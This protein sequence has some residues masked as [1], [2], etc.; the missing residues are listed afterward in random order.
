[1]NQ[2]YI[3]ILFLVSISFL[4]S[5]QEVFAANVLVVDDDTGDSVN[6]DGALQA[7]GHTVTTVTN[8][9]VGGSNPTLQGTLSQYDAVYWTASGGIGFGEVHSDPA[10]F[11]NLNSYVSDG[12]CVFVTGYDSVASPTDPPLYTFL[13]ATSSS[14]AVSSTPQPIVNI[15]NAITIGVRD[16]RGV[17]PLG[18]SSDMD[19]LLEALAPDTI[20]I[21]QSS[22]GTNNWSW[23]LREPV[24]TNGKI[25]YVSNG[26]SGTGQEPNWLV[27]TNDGFGAYNAALLNFALACSDSVVGGELLQIDTT[28]LMLAGLHSTI[29]MLPI[30]AGATGVGIFYIKTRMN[31]E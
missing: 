5:S 2:I 18:G 21:A 3:L 12:G 8:D 17:Q 24:G 28:A 10:T 6:I 31:K 29:W 14:D 11:T 1:M 26:L 19:N 9:F 7:G 25:A 30:L 23:T 20:G 16:I 27:T 13:G 15:A 4:L 22:V